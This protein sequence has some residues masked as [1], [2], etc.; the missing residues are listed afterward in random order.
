M[1]ETPP[2]HP[3]A[4][5]PA[6]A[7]SFHAERQWRRVAG[8]NRSAM[9]TKI[10]WLILCALLL[11]PANAEEPQKMMVE[12]QCVMVAPTA[13][14]RMT[15][16]FTVLDSHG[17]PRGGGEATNQITV[18]LTGPRTLRTD[19]ASKNVV[20]IIELFPSERDDLAARG[21]GMESVLKPK[22]RLVFFVPREHP[23]QRLGEWEIVS[24]MSKILPETKAEPGGAANRSQPAWPKTNQQPAAAGSGR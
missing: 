13:G 24:W 9:T 18:S 10:P 11:Q 20:A 17:A 7:V 22:G 1:K 12:L 21:L 15:A 8:R 4:A 19:V 5:N 6:E 23:E 3:A 2:N 16:R 14:L